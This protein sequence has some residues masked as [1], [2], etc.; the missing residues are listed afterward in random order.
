[1]NK[2][3]K[4]CFKDGKLVQFDAHSECSPENVKKRVHVNEINFD[5]N[6]C[7]VLS[8]TGFVYKD[9][10]ALLS[11]LPAALIS[12]DLST[13]KYAE[14]IKIIQN[15]IVQTK[16]VCL[17]LNDT[18]QESVEAG[19]NFVLDKLNKINTLRKLKK[20]TST[21][22]YYVEPEEVAI[23]L[24]WQK[25]KV[26]PDTNIPNH[27]ISQATFQYISVIKTLKAIFSDDD[28]LRYYIKYNS[29]LKHKCETGIYRD[30]C[31]GSTCKSNEVFD[32][33]LAMHLQLGIDD[34]EICCPLKS[35]AGI[36]KVCAT[37]LQIRNLPMEYRS[38]LDNIYL[39]ALC[40]SANFKPESRS[41]N[42]VAERIVKEISEI[43]TDGIVVGE[44]VLKGSLVNIACDN[45]GA[46]S[47]FGF[48]ECFIASYFCRIC[49][50][51]K[52]ECHSLTKANKQ[53]YRTRASYEKNVKEAE[54]KNRK[55]DL[56]V[57]K[58]VRRNCK[59]ND[60]QYFHSI[61]NASVDVMHDIN[62]G[63][64]AYCL[65]D[66]FAYIID[67]KIISAEDIQRRVRDFNYTE[68]F[69]KI[70]PSL[71]NFDKHN[72][73]Q[74]ASQL[75]CLYVNL[76]F[77]FV[78][79]IQSF[80]ESWTPVMYLNKCLQIIYSTEMTENDLKNLEFYIEQHLSA[81]IRIFNRTLTAKHHF[82]IHY[83][84]IVRRM[85]PPIHLWTMR[86]E[87]KH[88][89]FTETAQKKKNFKNPTK[90]M[91]SHHQLYICKSPN[92][93]VD[94]SLSTISSQFSNSMQFK[95]FE[96]ILKNISDEIDSIRVHKFAKYGNMEYR[97]GCLLIEKNKINEIVHVLSN[98]SQVYL[99]C[100][101]QKV[102][103][104]DDFCHSFVLE[105]LVDKAFILN[106]SSI[107]QNIIY[108]KMIVDGEVHV[109][110]SNLSFQNIQ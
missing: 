41:Y 91:A 96:N 77:I 7:N 17:K 1:M 81:I 73:N 16:N 101:P 56:K 25:P 22:P 90:T 9:I 99:I 20:E 33:P 27:Q 79:L 72:L 28:F 2:R 29:E 109:V 71:I 46:N 97:A 66:F 55:L 38:K 15:I 45:L 82:F 24:K 35:K 103:R 100:E 75:Y 57:S 26:N 39:V 3:Y 108:D 85:G 42:D 87:A 8:S 30:F 44:R 62:E 23:G 47:V 34:F 94:I 58:G 13:K 76:P 102:V 37:Y 67:K 104:S 107:E 61:D 84:D 105:K 31:C 80:G 65:H 68:S 53:K 11:T 48:T 63:V 78:D 92:I 59:F 12:L 5:G 18:N 93:S 74:N 49:E 32:D 51:D 110:V 98:D 95:K 6:K 60:L 88:K 69:K 50:C 10:N 106:L 86:L 83:P 14:V 21:S 43:E 70:K 89:F 40:T 4:Y 36:H 54:K 52:T 64:V 19:T